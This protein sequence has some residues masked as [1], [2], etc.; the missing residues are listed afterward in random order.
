[1]QK[2]L[3]TIQYTVPQVQILA[4]HRLITKQFNTNEAKIKQ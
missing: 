2:T 4:Q 3:Q 1:M